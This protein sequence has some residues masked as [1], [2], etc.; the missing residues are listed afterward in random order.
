MQVSVI[1]TTHNRCELVQQALQSIFQQTRRPDEILVIDDGSNDDTA[2]SLAPL[3]DKIQYVYQERMGVSVSRNTGIRMARY[4]WIAFLDS[5]DLWQPHKLARQLQSLRNQPEFL[6][7]YTG[8]EWRRHG[9]W[10]NQGR[11]HRKHSGWIYPYCLPLCIISPSS[12]MLH[13]SLFDTVGLFDESLPACEDYDLW[14]R[15]TCRYPALFI[16]ERLIIKRAGDWPQ[17]SQQHSLDRY[18]ILS[19]DKILQSNRLNPSQRRDTV[20]MLKQKCR[21]F[22]Q[23]CR[24]H[25]RII[26]AL[27]A[28]SVLDKYA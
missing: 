4:E 2:V 17:L 19:L 24:K 3:A 6:I 20:D 23:G 9:R 12:V 14:L 10:M 15:I 1:I 16:P 11:K 18:R 5:D 25:D 28:E 8:E 21:V 27:W 26:D 7:C 13:R 22:A